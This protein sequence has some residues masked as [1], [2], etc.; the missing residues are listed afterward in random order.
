MLQITLRFLLTD[1]DID[2]R[3]VHHNRFRFFFNVSCIPPKDQLRAAELQL[4]RSALVDDAFNR[5]QVLVYD[6]VRPGIKN[7]REPV[8]ILI[9]S[10]SIKSNGNSTLSLDVTPAVKRWIT[11][12]KHNFGILVHISSSNKNKTTSLKQ[13]HIRLKRQTTDSTDATWN[14][15]QPI[16]LTYTD[17]GQSKSRS[18]REAVSNRNRRAPGRGRNK[19]PAQKICQRKA[20]YVSLPLFELNVIKKIKYY[21]ITKVKSF[22]DTLILWMWAGVIGLSPLLDTKLT[23][24]KEIANSL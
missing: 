15:Y 9:D 19:R 10:K 17:D 24:V 22:I 7:K 18:T 23:I 20:L 1:S 4:T 14:N 3:F 12:P 6:I 21:H 16:L 5:Y 11:T 2:N 13:Q 8:L